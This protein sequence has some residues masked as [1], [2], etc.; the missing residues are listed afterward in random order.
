ML[1][2]HLQLD[3]HWKHFLLIPWILKL[4]PPFP[5]KPLLTLQTITGKLGEPLAGIEGDEP[6]AILA[7]RMGV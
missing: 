7:H 6:M 4:F 3:R 2:T 5:L 1:R